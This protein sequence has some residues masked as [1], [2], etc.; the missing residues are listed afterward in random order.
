M[1]EKL[2]SGGSFG[3]F[4]YYLTHHQ[5]IFPTSL[6]GF[7]LLSIV[8]TAT[9]TFLGCQ[10]LIILAFVICFQQDDHPIFLNVVAHI[11][12]GIFP[13]KYHAN[14]FLLMCKSKDKLLV[15]SLSHHTCISSIFNPLLYNITYPSLLVT[16]Y[17]CPFVMVS[18]WL[19][20]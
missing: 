7:S 9:P 4:I 18:M 3:A 20:H 12:I 15:I 10:A 8:Q 14:T 2:L 13:F 6:G 19:Y 11:E 17:G 1:L 5:A 16:S